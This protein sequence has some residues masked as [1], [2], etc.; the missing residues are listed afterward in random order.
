MF[1]I[2][3]SVV[4]CLLVSSTATARGY[5]ARAAPAA[6]RADEAGDSPRADAVAPVSR[7]RARQDLNDAGYL[8]SAVDGDSDNGDDASNYGNASGNGNGNG[9]NGG[10][11]NPYRGDGGASF[12]TFA[13]SSGAGGVGSGG[14]VTYTG[15]YQAAGVEP[16]KCVYKGVMTDKEIARCKASSEAYMARHGVK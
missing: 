1:R 2:L 7:Y 6:P 3:A 13:S 10:G 5:V 8:D 12:G 15:K 16:S 9:G 11:G 14:D 4:F